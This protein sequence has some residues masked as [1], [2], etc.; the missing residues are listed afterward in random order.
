MNNE[1]P[2]QAIIKLVEAELSKR[3][4]A[5]Q[6]QLIAMFPLLNFARLEPEFTGVFRQDLYKKII[7]STQLL[8]DRMREARVMIASLGDES[9]KLPE[10]QVIVS[11]QEMLEVWL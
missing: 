8:L 4:R 2:P 10:Q 3:E 11:V 5:I 1:T 6:A 7:S 9:S